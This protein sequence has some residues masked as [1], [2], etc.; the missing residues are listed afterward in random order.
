MNF[1]LG[2]LLG[3]I[4]W[5]GFGSLW[6]GQTIEPVYFWAIWFK[7]REKGWQKQGNQRHI[8]DQENWQQNGK[9]LYCFSLSLHCKKQCKARF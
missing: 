2:A 6:V 3:C 8:D 4:I 1:F 7:T 5:K 9:L